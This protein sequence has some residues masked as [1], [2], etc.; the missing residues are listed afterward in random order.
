[1]I[2][3]YDDHSLPACQ[4]ACHAD[5]LNPLAEFTTN[6]FQAFRHRYGVRELESWQHATATARAIAGD[7][8]CPAV[9]A[10]EFAGQREWD[11]QVATVCVTPLAPTPAIP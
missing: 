1:M 10:P 9:P 8:A 4:L 2:G 5:P 11:I 7:R 6:A 3:E